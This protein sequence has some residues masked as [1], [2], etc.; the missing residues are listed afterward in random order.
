MSEAQTV[1][2]AGALA[3]ASAY[4]D[5][6][7][8]VYRVRAIKR[9]QSSSEASFQ[10]LKFLAQ[11]GYQEAKSYSGTSALFEL[12]RDSFERAYQFN[13]IR[14]LTKITDRAERGTLKILVERRLTS[15]TIGLSTSFFVLIACAVVVALLGVVQDSSGVSEASL[16]VAV[17]ALIVGIVASDRVV[18]ETI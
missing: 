8:H 11:C 5:G 2:R 9:K 1:F 10:E 12:S 3:R 13:N 15:V 18:K 14:Q 4:S 7:D 16:Y 17:I 6:S